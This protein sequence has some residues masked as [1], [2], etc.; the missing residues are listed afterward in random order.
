MLELKKK[1]YEKK[2]STNKIKPKEKEENIFCKIPDLMELLIPDCVEEKKDYIYLGENR[3]SR[4]FVISAYPSKTYLGWLDRIFNL[5]GD[6]SLSII[7]RKANED[8]VIRQ[9]TKKVTVLESEYH[10]YQTRGNIENLH[11]LEQMAY[12]YEEIRRDIQE[13]DEKLFFI[14]IYLRINASTLENLEER[15]NL[16]KNEFAKISSKVRTLSFRQLSGL[17][18]NL[19]FNDS[20]IVDYE[21]NVTTKGLATMFPIANCNSESSI[22]GV[23]IGRNY[24]TG[25]PVYLDTFSKRLTNPHIVVLG[26]TGAGKS[27]TM[28]ILSARSLVT[29]NTQSA[30]L[31]IEGEYKNRTKSLSGKIIEI[32]QGMP[33]GINIF[34]VD[35]EKGE[36]GIEKVNILN[37]VAEI[38]AI[39]SGIMKNYMAR[40]L[41]AKELVDIEESVIEAYKEKGITTLKDS[42]YEREGGKIGNKLTL[43]PIKKKMPT[44]SDFHKILSTKENSKELSEILTGFLKGKSLGMFDC[45]SNINVDEHYIDFDLSSIT[46]EITKFYASM[47]ITTWITERYMRRSEKYEEKSVYIDEAWTMLKYEETANFIE[48][49]ARRARKRGVRLV[50]A[51]QLPD[52]LISSPQGRAVLNCCGTAILMKQSPISVDKIIDYFKLSKGTREFL[53]KAKPGEALLNIEGTVSA[54]DIEVLDKEVEMLKV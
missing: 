35:I 11:P 26:A 51:T 54:I 42:I 24:F 28:D 14:T 38:R 29:K 33:S 3:Y 36:N 53:L 30:I 18:A 45:V 6:I 32:K 10:T 50:I 9:L 47:V 49:L 5:L 21:R 40:N 20:R 34:D 37:K 46:D 17:K 16:L 41:N 8:T 15:S 25:L 13:K 23:P 27:V 52:E 48:N 44:L 1:E 39:L 12:D 22:D 31:D 43:D 7:A 4:N 19:P 2:I